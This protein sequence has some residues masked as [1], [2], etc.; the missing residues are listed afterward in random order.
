MRET[1]HEDLS[2]LAGE[3]VLGTLEGEAR[4]EFERRLSTDAELQQMVETWQRH[5][6]P[7]TEV[8][9]PVRPPERIWQEIE[10]SLRLNQAEREPP[11]RRRRRRFWHNLRFW[12]GWA[13]ASSLAAA[14]LALWIG[15]GP[16]PG[17]EVRLIAILQDAT[18]NPAWLLTALPEAG[19]WSARPIAPI[20]EPGRV[21]QLWLLPGGDRSPVSLGVLDQV[22]ALARPVL[23]ELAPLLTSGRAVAVSLEPPGGS[24]TGQ[25]T[26]PVVYQGQLVRDLP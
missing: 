19:R 1:G 14:C 6:A 22:G 2:V 17:P 23:A 15:L 12:R 5:L 10:T 25:P 18:A 21:H 9:Q 8:I 20:A 4:R 7:L 13:L 16:Q 11:P 24:P 3:Y 26:G